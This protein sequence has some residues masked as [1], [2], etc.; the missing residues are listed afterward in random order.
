MRQAK[1][2]KLSFVRGRYTHNGATFARL[3]ARNAAH[4]VHLN[5]L[6]LRNYDTV[7]R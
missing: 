4:P 5:H 1:R 7:S 2:A 6:A 3:S